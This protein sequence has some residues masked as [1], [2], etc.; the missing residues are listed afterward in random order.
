MRDGLLRRD[1]RLDLGV[2]EPLEPGVG[3][4]EAPAVQRETAIRIAS[5]DGKFQRP[6]QRLLHSGDPPT[7][8]DEPAAWDER[9]LYFYFPAA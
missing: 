9:I 1:P 8:R 3:I 7:A 5:R 4:V 2:V 6:V